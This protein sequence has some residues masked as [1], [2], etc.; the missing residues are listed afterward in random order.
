MPDYD[1]CEQCFTTEG[2]KAFEGR[3]DFEGPF[4]LWL[5]DASA[6]IRAAWLSKTKSGREESGL[7]I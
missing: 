6:L 3:P 2:I 4:E 5:G 1:L 7:K